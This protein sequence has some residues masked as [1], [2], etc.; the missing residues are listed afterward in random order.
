MFGVFGFGIVV[1]VGYWRL[2]WLQIDKNLG[3]IRFSTNS[4]FRCNGTGCQMSRISRRDKQDRLRH[5]RRNDRMSKFLSEQKIFNFSLTDAHARTINFDRIFNL[6]ICSL[7][8]Q[9]EFIVTSNEP[10]DKTSRRVLTAIDVSR[11]FFQDFSERLHFHDKPTKVKISS[12]LFLN[13][14]KNG[15]RDHYLSN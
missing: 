5:Q 11:D 2:G 14:P 1:S 15:D 6:I 8:G 10:Q 3:R 9:K 12:F 7:N 13:K 4:I